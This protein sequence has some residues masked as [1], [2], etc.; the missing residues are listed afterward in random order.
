MS[1]KT[2]KMSIVDN[3]KVCLYCKEKYRGLIVKFLNKEIGYTELKQAIAE[4][5]EKSLK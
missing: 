3:K 4:N 1:K 5:T 2:C